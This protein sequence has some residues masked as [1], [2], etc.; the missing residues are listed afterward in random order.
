MLTP[1]SI[2]KGRPWRVFEMVAQDY[3]ERADIERKEGRISSS[4]EF[5]FASQ[6]FHRIFN[7]FQA[8]HDAEN[9]EEKETYE[10]GRI[11]S[12]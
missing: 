6:A 8:E 7:A 2:P 3:S 12:G 9:V 10:E 11:V 5:R 4:K 1:S